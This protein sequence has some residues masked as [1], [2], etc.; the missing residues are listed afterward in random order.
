MLTEGLLLP[1]R[2]TGIGFGDPFT[3]PRT[4]AGSVFNTVSNILWLDKRQGE[5]AVCVVICIRST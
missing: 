4:Q 1:E 2:L 3:L 5:A